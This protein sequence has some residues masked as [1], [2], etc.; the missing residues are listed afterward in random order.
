[1]LLAQKTKI[2]KITTARFTILILLLLFILFI[3][4]VVFMSID[5]IKQLPFT[6]E[7]NETEVEQKIFTLVN[8]KREE[9][10]NNPLVWNNKIYTV[11]KEY[12]TQ[13]AENNATFSHIS[14]TGDTIHD[15]IKKENL[16][17]FIAGE[18]LYLAPKT[19]NMSELIFDGWMKSPGHRSL[20]IDRDQFFTDGAVG[21]KCNFLICYATLNMIDSEE[22][23][24]YVIQEYQYFYRNLNDPAFGLGPSY[25]IEITIKA[26]KPID[27][28][29][30]HSLKHLKLFADYGEDNSYKR[31]LSTKEF[32]INTD[33]ESD[34]YIMVINTNPTSAAFEYTAVYN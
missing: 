10:G 22:H 21:V 33:A 2:A 9:L 29:F 19:E 8:Q 13:L 16:F 26:D 17:F 32:S 14:E 6:K 15:R 27:I 1:M 12:S 28:Y 5:V 11:A 3:P 31:S 34:K 30:F 7:I 18:N 23:F 24:E 25:P 4:A 20:L